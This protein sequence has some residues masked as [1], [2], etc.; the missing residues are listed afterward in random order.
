MGVRDEF[1]RRPMS[2]SGG[3][4]VREGR[5]G[6]E[7]KERKCLRVCRSVLVIRHLHWQG[8]KGCGRTSW[9]EELLALAL[10]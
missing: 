1:L 10:S 3:E 6:R 8:G 4:G 7:E 9:A 5:A 2:Q